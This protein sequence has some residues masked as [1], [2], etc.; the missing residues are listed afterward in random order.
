[1]R[2]RSAQLYCILLG[3]ALYLLVGLHPRPD[4]SKP[5]P[6]MFFYVFF[7]GASVGSFPACAHH[8]FHMLNSPPSSSSMQAE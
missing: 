7:I 5:R 4:G 2:L 1:M 6:Q 3:L 8:A